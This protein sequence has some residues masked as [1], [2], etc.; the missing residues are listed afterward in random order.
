MSDETRG[1][2]GFVCAYTPLPLIDAA[3]FSSYRIL[4]LGEAADQSGRFLHDGMCPH[5]KRILDRALAKNLPQLAGTVVMNSCDAMR[6]LADA[7]PMTGRTNPITLVDL[8]TTRSSSSIAY[9]AGELR[10][11][12][13]TLCQWSGRE[14]DPER[15]RESLHRYD[16]LA[17]GLQRLTNRAARGALG[18]GWARLQEMHN[19][20][21]A[22]P[23]EASLAAVEEMEAEPEGS[24]RTDGKIPVLIFGNV[25]PDPRSFEMIESCGC[26]IV[27]DD[28]CTGSRQIVPFH[29]GGEE[30]V[31]FGLARAT[32]ARPRCA[33]TIDT[34]RPGALAD[35]VLGLVEEAGARGAIAHVMK[36]CDP[37]L[38][39][40]PAIRERL[41]AA[42]VPLL[43]LEGDCT[44]RTLGQ[45]RTRIEA[46]VEI[47]GG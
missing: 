3:G 43:V 36:F 9:F 31:F 39:R 1:T 16:R 19:R 30:D 22:Q 37:Y 41:K 25:L 24:E 46:F 14:I 12:A 32:L 29:L 15:V 42:G 2:V 34:P 27:A 33:R 40:L 28:L 26:R 17:F 38:A 10:R 44:N 18:G 45:Q 21:A 13:G 23:V 7:L 5:V 8:P 4:P 11:L 47:L 35:H 20:S 6:R